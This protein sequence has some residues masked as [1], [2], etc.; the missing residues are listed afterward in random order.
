MAAKQYPSATSSG[1]EEQAFKQAK[2][3]AEQFND[4][5]TCA[6]CFSRYDKPKV[7]PC[8]HLYCQKCLLDMVSSA[9]DKSQI[10]CPQCQEKHLVPSEGVRGFKTY[11]TI[12]NLLELLHIHE[13]TSGEAPN[14]A[15]TCESGLD[16]NPAIARCLTCSDYLCSECLSLHKKMR[17]TASHKTLTFDEIKHSDKITGVRSVEKKIYCQDHDDEILKMYCTTCKEAICRDCALVKHQSHKYVFVRDIRPELQQQ[18]EAL[19]QAVQSKQGEFQSQ[20]EYLEEVRGTN[21]ST[22]E[23]CEKTVNASCQELINAIEVRRATLLQELYR[24]HE[25]EEKSISAESNTL[26]MALVRLTNSLRFTKQL[27]ENG[28]DLE[29]VTMSEQATETLDS[30]KKMAVDKESFRPVF[31]KTEFGGKVNAD[32][33]QYGTIVHSAQPGP[34]DVVVKNLRTKASVGKEIAFE[35][36][37]SARV[38]NKDND[39]Q[40]FYGVK[41]SN[42]D[43]DNVEVTVQPSGV[44]SLQVS[45]VPQKAGN[46]TVSIQ[47]N[48]VELKQHTFEV[49]KDIPVP[50]NFGYSLGSVAELQGHTFN[51]EVI[52]TCMC[53]L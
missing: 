28:D 14:S 46:H 23:S 16:E 29:V 51:D 5:L 6:I 53:T 37:L 25:L 24:V 33:D 13:S 45:C 30:L 10:A 3:L 35:V 39:T 31:I 47:F 42:H 12:N 44:S 8:L 41:V 4:E 49:K 38:A 2:S 1:E 22:L 20:V 27:V 9:R 52:S 19:M 40:K 34:A 50:V 26:S 7:L 18:L 36:E 17:R 32:I 15:L 21:N 11:F 48:A 43:G